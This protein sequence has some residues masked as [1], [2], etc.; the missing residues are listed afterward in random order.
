M[1]TPDQTRIAVYYHVAKHLLNQNEKSTNVLGQMA[2]RGMDG[3]KCA[4]GCLLP[5]ELYGSFMEGVAV[6]SNGM[7]GVMSHLGLALDAL[8]MRL[9]ED[10]QRVHD[11]L[12]VSEWKAALQDIG[13]E[14][15]LP[16]IA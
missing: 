2:Y 3:R 1:T 13:R 15:R 16:A 4:I 11:W 5:D 6:N 10:L 9:L 8:V 7:M 12:P 14:H